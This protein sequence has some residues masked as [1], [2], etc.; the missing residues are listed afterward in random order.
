MSEP[1][2]RRIRGI[3]SKWLPNRQYGFITPHNGS[4]DVLAHATH[5]RRPLGEPG[6]LVEGEEVEFTVK[7][8]RDGAYATRI[9]RR[10]TYGFTDSVEEARNAYSTSRVDHGAP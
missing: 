9:T 1:D 3:V 10:G 2:P 8:G 7:D 4:G 5:V 6:V